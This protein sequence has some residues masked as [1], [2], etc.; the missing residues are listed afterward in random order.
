[1]IRRALTLAALLTAGGM[2]MADAALADPPCGRGW[3]RG[4]Y[5][6]PRHYDRAWDRRAEWERREAWRRDEWRRR[7]AWR[8]DRDYGAPPLAY[9]QP[10]PLVQLNIR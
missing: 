6:G 4:E 8:R 7:E 5:C 3:R 10:Q 1:M 2:M 9:R